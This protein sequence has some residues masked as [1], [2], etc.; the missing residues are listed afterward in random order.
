MAKIC[1]RHRAII[2]NYK[3]TWVDFSQSTIQSLT[4]NAP[5]SVVTINIQ[6]ASKSKYRYLKKHNDFE[7]NALY[8]DIA[9]TFPQ[10]SLYPLPIKLNDAITEI[11]LNLVLN[12]HNLSEENH[13]QKQQKTIFCT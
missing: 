9:S 11:L 8:L 6:C 5:F 2:L 12:T 10:I 13:F 1:G 7:L 3:T 4:K